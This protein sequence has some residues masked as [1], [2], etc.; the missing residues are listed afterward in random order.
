MNK[1]KRAQEEIVGF[2]VIII[3]IIVIGLVFLG[4]SLRQQPESTQ[5]QE[6]VM[7]D[8]MYSILSYSTYDT[9]MRELIKDCYL[10]PSSSCN[11]KPVCEHVKDTFSEILDEVLGKDIA[12]SYVNGYVLNITVSGESQDLINMEKGQITGNYFG[13]EIPIPASGTDLI[14]S[15]RY[16]ISGSSG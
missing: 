2:V 12:N 10:N 8:T 9:D 1:N 11:G 6:S 13:A 14:F 15:L 16:Y 3:M 4:F 5:H 7:L